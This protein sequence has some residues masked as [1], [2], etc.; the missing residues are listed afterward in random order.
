MCSGVVTNVELDKSADYPTKVWTGT[1]GGGHRTYVTKVGLII[2][3]NGGHVF[4]AGDNVPEGEAQKLFQA[5]NADGGSRICLTSY[6]IGNQEYIGGGY[7]GGGKRR[8]VSV[9][10]DKSKPNR[11]DTSKIQYYEVEMVLGVITAQL[12]K[13]ENIFGLKI[14]QL[15]DI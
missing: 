12:T 14:I 5:Q 3:A 9:P 4:R 15:T 13:Q 6:K 7:H 1:M 11:I 10:I 8:F 2:G